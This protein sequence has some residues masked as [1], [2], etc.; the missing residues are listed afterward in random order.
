MIGELVRLRVGR[1]LEL[2]N[3]ICD[4]SVWS[5]MSGFIYTHLSKSFPEEEKNVLNKITEI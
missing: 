3:E 1:R 2:R 5:R 4:A